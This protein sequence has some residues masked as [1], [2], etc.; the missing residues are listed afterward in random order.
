M[1]DWSSTLFGSGKKPKESQQAIPSGG[2]KSKLF[3]SPAASP[4]T[5]TSGPSGRGG[6]R[7]TWRQSSSYDVYGKKL[8]AKEGGLRYDLFTGEKRPSQPLNKLTIGQVMA[9][10]KQRTNTAAGAYQF[11]LD[12]LQDTMKDAGLKESDMFDERT[13]YK[14]FETFTRKN[15]EHARKAVGKSSLND[16]E[17]Y[18]MHFLGRS[19]GARFLKLLQENP[20]ANFASEFGREFRSNRALVDKVGGRKASVSDVFRELAVRMK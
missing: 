20:S 7:E 10:Q 19:G 15:E 6:F 2:W 14:L 9:L 18:S 8:F 1:R 16:A 3:G 5:R 12:T 11:T 4:P 17:R 13:Q